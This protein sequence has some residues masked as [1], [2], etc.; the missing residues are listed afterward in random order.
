MS[1]E[2]STRA[3]AGSFRCIFYSGTAIHIQD[4]VTLL[5]SYVCSTTTSLA[6]VGTY[7]LLRLCTTCPYQT[8]ATA[9]STELVWLSNQLHLHCTVQS[10]KYA[11]V[12]TIIVQFLFVPFARVGSGDPV[13]VLRLSHNEHT[14][15]N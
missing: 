11:P 15:Y 4:P 5:G 10:L 3:F 2:V 6:T 8:T 9:A 1:E 13:R 14:G 12:T 7:L